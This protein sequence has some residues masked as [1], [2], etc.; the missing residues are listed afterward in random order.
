MPVAP[1]DLVTGWSVEFETLFLAEYNGAVAVPDSVLDGLVLEETIPD[2]SGNKITYDWLGAAPQMREW[3]AEK[4]AQGLLKQTWDVVVKRFEAS[5][6]VDID[7]LRDGRGNP[8]GMRIREMA[9]NAARM[10]Y[11]LLSDIIR[12]NPLC[13]DGQNFFDTDHSE[14]ASGTQSN[15]LTGSG[16][17]QANIE[18][19]FYASRSKLMGY[20]D[21]KGETMAPTMFR[22]L[23]WIPNDP[24]LEQRFRTL[25][26]ATL[27][28][29]TSNILA[30]AFEIVVDPR[31]TDANDWFMFRLDGIMKPFVFINREAPNYEDDFGSNNE[32]TFKRRIGTASVVGR[33]NAAPLMW[34]KA[35]RVVNA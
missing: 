31:L 13:Y 19:D 30:N 20:K 15:S 18:T 2:F 11:N 16:T 3:L 28:S 12:T 8:Y 4:R 22:P 5:I 7:A 10:R 25:Q 27:I 35:L 17:T 9:R 21:D 14:G 6:D 29:N 23:V 32:A 26:G 24:T 34:Q 1:S 33:F